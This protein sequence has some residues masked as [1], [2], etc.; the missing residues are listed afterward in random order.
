[1]NEKNLVAAAAA[2]FSSLWLITK[3]AQFFD[4]IDNN[5]M[6]FVQFDP[7]WSSLSPPFSLGSIV[8][9]FFETS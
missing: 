1:M 9:A 5:Y 7:C 2:V 8:I 4:V 3:Q 6:N